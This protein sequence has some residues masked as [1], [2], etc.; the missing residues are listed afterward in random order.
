MF[1]KVMVGYDGS[2]YAMDAVALGRGIAKAT[3]AE[4]EV[5]GVFHFEPFFDTVGWGNTPPPPDT[6]AEREAAV[7]DDIASAVPDATPRAIGSP[8]PAHGLHTLAEEV[9]ADLI[10]V[11]SA[12]R[13]A[14]G[15]VLVGSVGERL[16]HGSPYP[17][18]V[19]P[20]G[21]A[22]NGGVR[23]ET[24][25]VGFDAN[26][27][28]EAALRAATDLAETVG[29]K[30][31]IVATVWPEPVVYGRGRGVVPTA[32]VEEAQREHL[33]RELDRA[34][35]EVSGRV[36][37]EVRLERGEPGERLAE[38]DV[39]LMIVGSRGYGPVRSVLL[40]G[41]SLLLMRTA[42]YPVLVVPRGASLGK[43]IGGTEGDAGVAA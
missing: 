17:V 23:L 20:R 40:G 30:V 5:A 28:A 27:E 29:A 2:E 16:L 14:L 42:P 6:R 15:R 35:R 12:H 8:S 1:R 13:G 31:L 11:G 25:G 38:Q 21:F 36:E 39:D 4:F 10:V 32:P 18:A 33:Q 19:A 41:V 9:S 43:D 22:E 24:I 7:L 26:D 37:A 3:G 34:V